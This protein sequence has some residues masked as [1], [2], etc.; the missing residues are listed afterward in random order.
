MISDTQLY[1]FSHNFTQQEESP[2]EYWRGGWHAFYFKTAKYYLLRKKD[3]K[4][5]AKKKTLLSVVTTRLSDDGG[6]GSVAPLVRL[7]HVSSEWN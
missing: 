5:F 1:Y 2:L 6:G 4:V 7:F 3:Y